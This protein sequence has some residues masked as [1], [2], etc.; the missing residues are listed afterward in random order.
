MVSTAS[1][2]AEVTAD[3]VALPAAHWSEHHHHRHTVQHPH[4]MPDLM[5]SMH[6]S[7]PRSALHTSVHHEAHTAAQSDICSPGNM[8]AYGSHAEAASAQGRSSAAARQTA[9]DVGQVRTLAGDGGDGGRMR[10]CASSAAMAAGCSMQGHTD[11]D[12]Q[13]SFVAPESLLQDAK[14]A[15]VV[16][17]ED[18]ITESSKGGLGEAL[19]N[20]QQSG[21]V[22]ADQQQPDGINC[23][24]C[25]E[26]AISR[27]QAGRLEPEKEH[28]SERQAS[29]RHR[30]S[31]R[32][33]RHRDRLKGRRHCSQPEDVSYCAAGVYRLRPGVMHLPT[34]KVSPVSLM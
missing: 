10:S 11:P 12:I 3:C 9:G 5:S 13:E 34:A 8:E 17:C 14:P 23:G 21:E 25:S 6:F 26:D 7:R 19:E 28:S 27:Q 15:Q 1:S 30:K 20:R 4:V 29:E 31:E 22:A 32:Q 18:C 2:P 16:P 24:V 33:E